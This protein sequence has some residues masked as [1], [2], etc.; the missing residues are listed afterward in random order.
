MKT[1]DSLEEAEDEGVQPHV[2][3]GE[4]RELAHLGEQ[5]VEDTSGGA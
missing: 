5:A 1:S 3:V 2:V 4:L